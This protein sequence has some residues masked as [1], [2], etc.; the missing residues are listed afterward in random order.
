MGKK[1]LIT[2][3]TGMIGTRL[4]RKLQDQGH[5]VSL[6][7]RS[8]RYKGPF[9]A[10]H[11]D[12]D[13]GELDEKAL[14]QAD[15]IIHLAGLNIGEKRWSPERKQ[16]ILD[17]RVKSA[18]LL[19]RA[20]EHRDRKPQAFISASAIGFYGAVTADTIFEESAPAH[21]DFL[22]RTCEIWE[23]AA[24]RFEAIGIRT[25]KIRIGIVLSKQGGALSKLSWP[26]RLGVG[27]PIGSG[28][29][30]MPWIHIED[31]C[32]IYAKAIE[33]PHMSGA[34]NGVAPE[35]LTNRELT[36]KIARVL[37]RPLWLPAIPAGIM[38]LLFGEMSA[39]LLR[40]SR[41]SSEKIRAAGFTFQYPDAASAL[42]QLLGKT[43][44]D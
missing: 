8:R 4:G 32:G 20:L 14:D 18:E 33:D 5:Q 27:A 7:S 29:Q 39:M 15:F 23:K 11:W 2:G 38:K 42:G 28:S 6:L 19:Y 44:A 43:G 35:H 16:Q 31:L 36:K 25:V 40:G 22:G 12:P 13:R 26:V 30:Y 34:Y 41:V 1:I 37:K 17:S 9:A 21:P 10:Y 3:G 24:D